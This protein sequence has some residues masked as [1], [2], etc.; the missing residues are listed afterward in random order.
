M[1]PSDRKTDQ[2]SGVLHGVKNQVK[3]MWPILRKKKYPQKTVLVHVHEQLHTTLTPRACKCALRCV[4]FELLHVVCHSNCKE[5]Q[6]SP[7][8]SLKVISIEILV[9][10]LATSKFLSTQILTVGVCKFTMNEQW[11]YRNFDCPYHVTVYVAWI[12][13]NFGCNAIPKFR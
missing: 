10:R 2:K 4:L 12:N 9:V 8:R 11:W 7:Y 5:T 13:R 1:G 3:N 6:A